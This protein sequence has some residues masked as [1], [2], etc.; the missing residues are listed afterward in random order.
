M[1]LVNVGSE[2]QRKRGTTFEKGLRL[3]KGVV[4]K[5]DDVLSKFA[6]VA[7][8]NT[9]ED[10]RKAGHLYA[11]TGLSPSFLLKEREPCVLHT[12]KV[13]LHTN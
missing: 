2:F 12:R 10:L 5:K 11:F 6:V 9:L 13:N 1:Q 3:K 4:V 8:Y 7:H